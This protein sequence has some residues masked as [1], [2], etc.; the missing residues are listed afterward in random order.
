MHV[1]PGGLWELFMR[2]WLI[3]KGFKASPVFV[4]R[5]TSAATARRSSAEVVSAAM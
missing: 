2:V 1:I 5:P 3:A 4:Q